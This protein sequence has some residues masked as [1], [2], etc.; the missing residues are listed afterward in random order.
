MQI[1]N[2]EPLQLFE[3]ISEFKQHIGSYHYTLLNNQ[4]GKYHC[5]LLNNHNMNRKVGL[6]LHSY[7][8]KMLVQYNLHLLNT[9][10][11]SEALVA[12]IRRTLG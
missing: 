7:I 4:S 5:K 1:F 10:G 11:V 8:L 9:L 2:T 3:T 12:I 6:H